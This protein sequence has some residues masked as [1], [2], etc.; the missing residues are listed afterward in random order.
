ML[1]TKTDML[2]G[3]LVKNIILFSIPVMISSVLQLFF[4]AA[5]LVIVGRFCGSLSVAAVG[6]TSSLTH[7]LVNFFVGFSVGTGVA[8]AQAIGAGNRK[9]TAL[10]VHTAI[11]LAVIS[12]SVITVLG[13]AFSGPLL[14][15]MGTPEEILPLSAVYMRLYFAGM[16]FN[17][18]YNYGASILRAA[19]DTKGPLIYLTIA[20]VV[21][22]VLNVIFVVAF[23]MNVAGVAL[24]TAISQGVSAVLVVLSLMNRG[25]TV[26]FQ[27]RKMKIHLPSLKKI[28]KIGVPSGLQ[29]SVF[30]M[31]NVLIQSSVNSFGSVFVSGNAAA[32]NIEAFPWVMMNAF[33]QA[34]L[35]FSGQN[36]GASQ[37]KRVKKTYFVCLISVII[38]GITTGALVNLFGRQLLSIYITDSPEA[39]SDGMIRFLIVAGTYFIA[40]IMEVATGTLRGIG[41]SLIPMLISVVGVCGFRITWIYTVFQIPRFHTPESLYISY[42]IS[43]L[44]SFIALNITFFVVYKKR[45]ENKE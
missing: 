15:L 29:S 8:V 30:S 14:G 16:V 5:D 34:A 38:C 32:A 40:G 11:P 45:F 10:V 36:V 31:S 42:P 22:V 37:Y 44:I 6:A 41:E 25:D 24:A 7:L 2:S 39:I 28:L 33:H 3:S 1:K 23:N 27:W 4:N 13:V 9:E 43:W 35:N 20:G 21:N 17:M 18:V 26:R 19:G 12:G